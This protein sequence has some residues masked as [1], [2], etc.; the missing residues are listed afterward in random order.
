MKFLFFLFIILHLMIFESLIFPQDNLIPI[1]KIGANNI[2]VS[3]YSDRYS[4]SPRPLYEGNSQST[5]D[6]FLFSLIAEKLWA[7]EAFNAGLLSEPFVVMSLKSLENLLLKDKLYFEVIKKKVQYSGSEV[8][9]IKSFLIR[10]KTFRMIVSQDSVEI[11]NIKQMINSGADFDSLLMTRK[12]FSV[13]DDFPLKAEYGKFDDENLQT[14]IFAAGTGGISEPVNTRNGWAIFKI[15]SDELDLILAE[16][17]ETLVNKA[18]NIIEEKKEKKAAGLFIDSLFGGKSVPVNNTSSA[19]LFSRYFEFLQSIL[20]NP[21]FRIN[22]FIYDTYSLK[23]MSVFSAKEKELFLFQT[24]ESSATIADFLFFLMH[25]KIPVDTSDII[26]NNEFL[27]RALRNFIEDIFFSNEAR[28][29]GY[30]SDP[31]LRQTFDIWKD[32]LLSGIIVQKLFNSVELTE[33]E[34]YFHLRRIFLTGDSNS[35]S[36]ISFLCDEDVQ[37]VN[38][39]IGLLKEGKDFDSLALMNSMEKGFRI[40]DS[41]FIKSDHS[42]FICGGANYFIIG[43]INNGRLNFILKYSFQP[44]GQFFIN[45]DSLKT[46]YS[47]KLKLAKFDKYMAE[48]TAELARRNSIEINFKE[49]EKYD[50]IPFSS[51]AVRRIGFGGQIPAFPVLTPNFLWY[52]LYIGNSTLAP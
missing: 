20:K 16:D 32:N 19:L 15:Y 33:S 40:P 1:A 27:K 43:P 11:H 29:R 45:Y 10:N 47:Y 50:E 49:I 5:K 13:Q 37:M 46:E 8:E 24:D 52:D 17:Q 18:I 41:V 31:E 48:K 34:I 26:K 42:K 44:A 21:E 9:E 38:E 4:F 28:K 23:F 14:Q 35:D 36:L 12:E 2:L 30:S 6:N 51:I 22:P 39:W 3:E 25:E 7:Q